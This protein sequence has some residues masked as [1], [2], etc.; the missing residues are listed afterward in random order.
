MRR[1][2]AA[3]AVLGFLCATSC[4]EEAGRGLGANEATDPCDVDADV[5]LAC[6][7]ESCDL[8]ALDQQ[9]A[10]CSVDDKADGIG[11]TFREWMERLQQKLAEKAKACFEAKDTGCLERVYWALAA[12]AKVKGLSNAANMMWNFLGCDEDPA[13]VDSD[14]V[15]AD[16]S[17]D[18]VVKSARSVTWSEAEMLAANGTDGD[19]EVE[20][21]KTPVSA[22]SADIW[23]A[24]GNFHVGGKAVIT[25]ASG[26][27]EKVVFE[28]E[29]LDRYDWHPGSAAGGDAEGV[30]SFKDD[31]AQFLV[32]EGEACEFDMYSRWSETITEKP[33]DADDDGGD[34]NA[35]RDDDCCEPH[36]NKGCN[37]EACQMAVCAMD[38]F[39]CDNEWEGI[40]VSLAASID[41]CG[42]TEDPGGSDSGG[43]DGGGETGGDEGGDSGGEAGGESG[44]DGGAMPGTCAGVCGQA[45]P[46][47][48]GC[49]PT[50]NDFDDCCSDYADLCE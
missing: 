4:Q 40:C 6:S 42:C 5:L 49:D 36:G 12:G 46:V 43:M 32:D 24:M 31:W 27:V 9:L 39:C 14:D 44:G 47:D 7:D 45:F 15:R 11:D 41:A 16:E 13:E 3:A 35:G 18:A 1:G 29:A 2:L 10:A 8:D 20:I 50:C 26:K 28:F 37:D 19:V 33:E 17:V 38:S 34:T 21:A 30:S 25:I 22:D 48:C 23:Y